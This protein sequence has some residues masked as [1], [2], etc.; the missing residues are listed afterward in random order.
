[1]TDTAFRVTLR[2]L[3]EAED[4]HDRRRLY[5]MLASQLE[6]ALN[7]QA[8]N[9]QVVLWDVQEAA[10]KKI[11]QLHEHQSDTNMLLTGVMES[12]LAIQASVQQVLNAN[13]DTV[14]GL[15]KLQGQMKDSQAD[16]K[17]IRAEVAGVKDSVAE[18]Q[19]RLDTY[20]AG[21]KRD[22]VETLRREFDALKQA[23]GDGER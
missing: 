22:E 11:D 14:R 23:R 16:R 15:K 17:Q 4:A 20:I 13:K 8:N 12:L 10:Y 7:N 19:H 6:V 18:L 1:M 2:Q 3:A 5:D 21:S 9:T